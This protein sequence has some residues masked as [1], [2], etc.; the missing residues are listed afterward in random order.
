MTA[1]LWCPWCG[2]AL[3]TWPDP[4]GG[5]QQ[6]YVEDC[7]VC[8]RPIRFRVQYSAEQGDY[9]IDVAAER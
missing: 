6:D 4:S 9:V 2:E 1:A 5:E 7:A 8:C 3:E